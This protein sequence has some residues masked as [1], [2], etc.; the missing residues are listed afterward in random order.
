M[1]VVVGSCLV[2]GCADEASAPPTKESTQAAVDAVKKMQLGAVPT[3]K[4]LK[5]AS[6]V[7]KSEAPAK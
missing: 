4:G 1:V 7:N 2:T 6:E 3:P 5:P